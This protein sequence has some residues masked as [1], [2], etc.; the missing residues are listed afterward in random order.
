MTA[1]AETFTG[2]V[3]WPA[4]R[5]VRRVLEKTGQRASSKGGGGV[6]GGAQT[7]RGW[8]EAP[9][10]QTITELQLQKIPLGGGGFPPK[11]YNLSLAHPMLM[12]WLGWPPVLHFTPGFNFK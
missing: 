4:G 10:T 3:D 2:Q 5:Q 6:Q 12:A 11:C 7:R 8:C 9:K 1:V